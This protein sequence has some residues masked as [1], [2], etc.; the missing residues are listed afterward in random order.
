[1]HYVIFCKKFKDT[2]EN[3]Y[4][5]LYNYKRIIIKEIIYGCMAVSERR[6]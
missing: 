2:L 5:I 3:L 4:I 1:M 6:V